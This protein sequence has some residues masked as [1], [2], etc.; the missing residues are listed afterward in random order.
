MPFNLLT[1]RMLIKFKKEWK[2]VILIF[3]LVDNFQPKRVCKM[4]S[5]F[6][7]YL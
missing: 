4:F 2:F 6:R 1:N 5:D 7:D 3:L